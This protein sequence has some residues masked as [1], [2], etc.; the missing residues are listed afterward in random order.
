M[1][2]QSGA[3]ASAQLAMGSR[4]SLS[5]EEDRQFARFIKPNG[6]PI[7]VLFMC[8]RGNASYRMVTA[9]STVGQQSM[10]LPSPPARDS[11]TRT[12]CYDP[13]LLPRN[14][15]VYNRV[16]SAMQLLEHVPL[17]TV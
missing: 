2:G 10:C 17:H 16:L 3:T 12:A 6:L 8:P 13:Y 11:P 4:H 7:D 1:L 14:I 9:C 15:H 5:A